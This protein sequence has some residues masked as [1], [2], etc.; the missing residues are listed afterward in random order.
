MKFFVPFLLYLIIIFFDFSL[1]YALFFI[2]PLIEPIFVRLVI[3]VII[4]LSIAYITGFLFYF[5]NKI[6]A[7]RKGG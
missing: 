1:V 3:F 5:M 6:D 2:I 7:I 4:M